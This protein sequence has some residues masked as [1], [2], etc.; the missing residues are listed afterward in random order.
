[1][2]ELNEFDNSCQKWLDTPA[3][4]RDLQEGAMLMLK[5]NRNRVLYQNAINRKMFDKIEYV[6]TKYMADKI[7][8]CDK[9]TVKQIALQVDEVVTIN[10][11]AENKG[12]RTD[13]TDLAPEVQQI[14]N[15]NSERY[16][17][18]RALHER[19]KLLSGKGYTPCDRMPYLAEMLS[20]SNEIR[21]AWDVYDNAIAVDAMQQVT[22]AEDAN[23][24]PEAPKPIVLDAKRVSAN[25]KYLSDNKAKLTEL[26]NN[27]DLKKALELSMKMA[28][29]YAE[30]IA[31]GE[32]FAPEQ[33]AEFTALGI[34]PTNES[35]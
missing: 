31:A 5:I 29:R 25:R 11:K 17:R 8:K 30:M 21:D 20:L 22:D 1:M 10:A 2:S 19:L 9:E 16:A 3:N 6:L 35:N 33:V 34:V 4:E 7:S 32:T 18:V 14:P 23:K 13:H 12:M 24:A 28:Q 15:A 26:R 27:N